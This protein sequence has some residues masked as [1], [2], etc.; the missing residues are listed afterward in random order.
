[1]I[2]TSQQDGEKHIPSRAVRHFPMMFRGNEKANNAKAV[3]LWAA[4]EEILGYQ[5]D[6]KTGLSPCFDSTPAETVG[7]MADGEK[8]GREGGGGQ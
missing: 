6:T 8:K 1:M 2:E 4:R 7:R 5:C 3:R